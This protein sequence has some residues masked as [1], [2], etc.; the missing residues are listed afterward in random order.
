MTAPI[1]AQSNNRIGRI[2][3]FSQPENT[4]DKMKAGYIH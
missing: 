4:D 1:Y 2:G 3:V